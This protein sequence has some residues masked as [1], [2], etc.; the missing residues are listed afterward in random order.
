MHLYYLG[1]SRETEDFNSTG[2]KKS[3]CSAGDHGSIPGSRR[4]AGEGIGHPLQYSWI[5]L[6]AQMVKN[7]P[8]VRETCV[9]S[10]SWEVTLEEGMATHSNILAWRIPWTKE[11]DGLQSKGCKQSDTN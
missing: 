8:A 5:S 11:P 4:S 9:Q 6:M 10:L 1:L 3:I 2:K 7:P